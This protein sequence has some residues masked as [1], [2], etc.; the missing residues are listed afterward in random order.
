MTPY[1]IGSLIQPS[2]HAKQWYDKA[3][4]VLD[5]DRVYMAGNCV[6]IMYKV[7]FGEKTIRFFS[8]SDIEPIELNE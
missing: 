4:L 6:N 8:H 3:G 7:L 2:G 1:P 5:Y